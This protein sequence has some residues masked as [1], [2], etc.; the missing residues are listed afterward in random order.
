MA[1]TDV[2]V[3]NAQIVS[4]AGSY[5]GSI[6]VEKDRIAGIAVSGD[7]PKAERVIDAEGRFV[8]PGVVD[9]HTHIGG[10]YLLEQDFRTETP[11]AAAGGVTTVGVMH[12]AGRADRNYKEFV[13]EA[14][15]RP[16][17]E[18]FP[19]A[20]EIGEEAS[21]VDF[22]YTPYI[23]MDEQCDDIPKAARTFGIPSWKFYAN[24][25]E[26][27]TANVAP[28]WKYRMGM[29]G[30]FDDGLFWLGFEHIGKFG[31]AGIA[32]IHNENTEVATAVMKRLQKEGRTDGPA[33][34]DRCPPWCEAEHIYRYGLFSMK[35]GCRF[36][37]LHLSTADG[38]E[39]CD[40]MRKRG[41]RIVVET[42]PQYLIM[43]KND[44]PRVG[45]EPNARALKVNP[46]IRDKHHNEALWKGVQ[47][48]RIQCMGT[49]HV[50]TSIHEKFVR[51]DTGDRTTDPR[52][53]V[54]S[55]GSGFVGLDTL[56]P[57]MLSEG[58]HK[59]RVSLERVVEI[60][61][62]NPARTFGLYPKKG[63]LTV[64]ADADLVILD[65]D[66][67]VTFTADHLHSYA[68]FTIFDGRRIKGWPWLTMCRGKVVFEGNQVCGEHGHGRYLPRKLDRLMFPLDESWDMPKKGFG[69]R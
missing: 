17:S 35:A 48:G 32:L 69:K 22:F 44:A 38:L 31:P 8:I 18:R 15:A 21:M 61:C 45:N 19:V 11:A 40:E 59:G 39:A 56:L 68:D 67:E 66:K 26:P 36:Y 3:K 14:D 28:K 20:R 42:C 46:P 6:I 13:T 58:V 60:C 64:G 47:D 33:W 5:R 50:V 2:V 41:C 23:S 30:E 7:L 10:K 9:P 4:S 27:K 55:T 43:T 12:G 1:K 16:W 52:K 63:T 51:G 62:E 25:R 54:W 53:D 37:I 57:H 29:P 34:T 24:L 65:M 49:D